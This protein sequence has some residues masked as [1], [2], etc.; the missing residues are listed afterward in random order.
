MNGGYRGRER[1]I[2]F[3]KGRGVWRTLKNC[4]CVRFHIQFTAC[5]TRSGNKGKYIQ[6]IKAIKLNVRG[7]HGHQ[8]ATWE[9]PKL[10]DS[11]H[12]THKD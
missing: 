2:Y 4:D 8:G 3:F 1:I 9:L 10:H 7:A 5:L 12:L 11:A 6:Q